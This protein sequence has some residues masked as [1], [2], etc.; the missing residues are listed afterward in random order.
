MVQ[1]GSTLS[2]YERRLLVDLLKEFKDIFAL[3]NEDMLGIDPEIVQHRI[4]SI[5]KPSQL[6][7]NLEG[8]AQIGFSR[9]KR[10]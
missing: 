4:P 6:N 1:M 3:S 2:S 5:P 9:S 7:R 8:S 10:K